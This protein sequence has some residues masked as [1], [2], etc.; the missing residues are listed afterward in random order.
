VVALYRGGWSWQCGSL[1]T[2]GLADV[3]WL[4]ACLDTE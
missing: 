1:S 4:P 2:A 3:D